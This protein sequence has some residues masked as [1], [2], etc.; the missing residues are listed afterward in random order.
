MT[1]DETLDLLQEATLKLTQGGSLKDRLVDAYSCHLVQ[2]NAE[3]LPEELRSEF[4]AMHQAMQREQPLPRESKVR[5]SVRKMSGE[6]ALRHA[7]LVVRMFAEMARACVATEGITV[8]GRRK[9]R[10]APHSP[11]LKLFASEG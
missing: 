10:Q 5:A 2:L 7:G 6:E 11:I 1:S 9:I 4:A 8:T 3:L